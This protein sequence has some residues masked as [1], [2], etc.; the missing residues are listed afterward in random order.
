[1]LDKF[2]DTF[3]YLGYSDDADS[4]DIFNSFITSNLLI[5]FAIL[6]SW[7]Q[8]GGKPIE[9]MVPDTFSGAWEQVCD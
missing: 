1:M 2:V 7:K 3:H 8:F 4:V 5:G 9:C 6:I